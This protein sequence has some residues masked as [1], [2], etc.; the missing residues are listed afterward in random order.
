MGGATSSG[1]NDLPHRLEPVAEPNGVLWINDSKA[2]NI[3][4]T[5]VAL[6]S[7]ERPTVLL[8]GGRHKGEPYT[9][10][11]EDLRRVRLVIAYGEA[12]PVIA[13]DLAGIVDV[14]IVG[15]TFD[16]AVAYTRPA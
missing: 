5:R 15:G 3:E 9:A 12:A 13:E 4:S 8:L 10:L 14:E 16:A 7:M 1:A 6:R 11:R 2:T